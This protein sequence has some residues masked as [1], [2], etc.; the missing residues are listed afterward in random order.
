M[1]A[2]GSVFFSKY[3]TAREDGY[4]RDKRSPGQLLERPWGLEVD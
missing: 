2:R 4:Q 3:K 1:G